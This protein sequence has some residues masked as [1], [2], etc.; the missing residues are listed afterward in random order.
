MAGRK[1]GFK[2]SEE[3]K[4]K[5]RQAKLNNPTKY[6]LG[7]K[8]PEITAWLNYEGRK[9][10]EEWKAQNA[11]RMK[12]NTYGFQKGHRPVNWKGS[13]KYQNKQVLLRDDY[14]CQTCGMR[15]EEIMEVDHIIEKALGGADT[16]E[17][18][19]T[20]CPNCHA[21]KTIK[22]MKNRLLQTILYN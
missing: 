22:F 5:L 20:L 16:Q 12:G 8:R 19:Q 15:D 21:R 18:L 13:L 1:S 14:T 6:W 3:T 10:T 17:N 11:E 7:K 9:H 4:E 2:H